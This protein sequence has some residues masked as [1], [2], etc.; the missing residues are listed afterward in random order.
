VPPEWIY[1]RQAVRL[2]LAPG[3]RRRVLRVI[4]TPAALTSLALGERPSGPTVRAVSAEDVERRVGT[5]EH[6]GVAALVPPYP[7]AD[8]DELLRGDLVVALDQVSDPR[9]LGA[10]ARSVLAAGA[11]GVAMPRHRSATVTAAA[12]KASA[13]ATE[14]LPIVQVV[15]LSAFL[16]RCKAAG[17]WVYGADGGGPE[18]YTSLDLRSRVVLVFGSEGYGLRRLVAETCDALAALP[19]AGPVDSLN[20]SAAAAVFLFEARRQRDLPGDPHP[21]GR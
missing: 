15:N 7:F 12:V 20:V 17:F 11:A 2:A 5:R 8:E 3:A 6:Q 14:H 16:K 9:N 10:V 13:G 1:G 19:V 18:A 21:G 4:G